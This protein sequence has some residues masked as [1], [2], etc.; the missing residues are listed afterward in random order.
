LARNNLFL[1]FSGLAQKYYIRVPEGH[2][3]PSEE[4]EGGLTV[5]PK[6]FEVRFQPRG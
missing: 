6:A 3:A 5:V 2:P 1:F 4:V